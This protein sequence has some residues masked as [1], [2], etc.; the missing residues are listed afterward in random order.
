MVVGTA[1]VDIFLFKGGKFGFVQR[2]IQLKVA[3]VLGTE[4]LAT[5][6]TAAV[7]LAAIGMDRILE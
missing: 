6:L 4:W 1:V 5:E 3:A 7:T 2:W